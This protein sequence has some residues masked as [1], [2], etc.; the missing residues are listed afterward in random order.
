MQE[1]HLD[2]FPPP[3]KESWW[4][5]LFILQPGDIWEHRINDWGV[6]EPEVLGRWIW[7]GRKW[8]QIPAD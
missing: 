6:W 4:R 5:T 8:V 7:D 3:K 2:S 1:V